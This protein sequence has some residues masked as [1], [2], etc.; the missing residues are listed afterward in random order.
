MF[1]ETYM[2]INIVLNTH[3]LA[4]LIFNLSLSSSVPVSVS[5]KGCLLFV[6]LHSKFASFP[7]VSGFKKQ[8]LLIVD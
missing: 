2:K 7:S 6:A 3:V 1:Y 4:N 8:S 5:G